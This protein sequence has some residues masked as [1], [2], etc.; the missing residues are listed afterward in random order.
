MEFFKE[1]E[2]LVV[3]AS[4]DWR[5]FSY[6][7]LNSVGCKV[8]KYKSYRHLREKLNDFEKRPDLIIVGCSKPEN[9]EVRLIKYLHRKKFRQLILCSFLTWDE[10]RELF[11]A[12][13]DDVT[14]K[15]YDSQALFDTI[16]ESLSKI[17][18]RETI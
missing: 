1:K 14:K 4:L 2:F 7:S 12:G 9:R 8:A 17:A 5:E 11:L 16:T 6:C 13:A 10:M 15:P 18:V 3:D